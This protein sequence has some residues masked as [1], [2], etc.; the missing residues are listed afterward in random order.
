MGNPRVK[1]IPWSELKGFGGTLAPNHSSGMTWRLEGEAGD[2]IEV[3]SN[4]V[5]ST[6]GLV[7][8]DYTFRADF[9]FDAFEEAD[10]TPPAAFAEEYFRFPVDWVRPVNP[11]DDPNEQAPNID[12]P[13]APDQPPDID[14]EQPPDFQ[15]PDPPGTEGEHGPGER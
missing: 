7:N 10:I 2:P 4:P 9:V 1:N 14:P 8:D 3:P 12:A 5:D 15:A 13:P 11:F 6:F